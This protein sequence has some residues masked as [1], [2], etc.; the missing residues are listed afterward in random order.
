MTRTHMKML[1]IK[2]NY[3]K[4]R[5]INLMKETIYNIALIISQKREPFAF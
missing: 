1:S 3:K 5:G 2:I 4:K